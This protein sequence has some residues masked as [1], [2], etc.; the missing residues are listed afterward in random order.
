MPANLTVE[1]GKKYEEYKSAT[2]SAQK[3]RLLRELISIA[4]KHKGTEKLLGRLKKTLA[5]L[6]H[7]VE[8]ER[9]ARKSGG[10]KGIKKVA[11]MVVLVGPE[12][13]GKTSLFKAWTGEGEP[14]PYPN[15]TQE[16]ETAIAHYKE[17]KLQIIDT[18]SF[19]SSYGHNADAVVVCG[20][21]RSL[22]K[23]FKSKKIIFASDFKS[24]D[25]VLKA[26]WDSLGLIRVF[27]VDGT[28]PLL[29]KKGSSVRD[30][31]GKIHKSF[32]ENFEWAKIRRGK[33]TI[34]AGLDFEM[35]DG[36]LLILRSRIA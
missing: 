32:V 26:V 16:P 34:R 19:D 35:M 18:P 2:S 1:F 23:S 11:P 4:P 28:Y 33:R 22:A 8:A 27:T 13:S 15:S 24:P 3:I 9:R 7:K 5:R 21:D 6:E 30:V 36:D 14:Q 10:H 12:N 20:G 25:A 31:A 29:V 17:A